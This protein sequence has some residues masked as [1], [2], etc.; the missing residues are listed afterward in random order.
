MKEFFYITILL[1]PSIVSFGQNRPK[2]DLANKLTKYFY[3]I[4]VLQS[5]DSILEFVSKDTAHYDIYYKR[6]QTDKN[7]ETMDVSFKNADNLDFYYRTEVTKEMPSTTLLLSSQIAIRQSFSTLHKA[8][9][10]SRAIKS[11]LSNYFQ[12]AVSEKKRNT[13]IGGKWKTTYLYV[14]K[15]DSIPFMSITWNNHADVTTNGCHIDIY[16]TK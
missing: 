7:I 11:E 14:N 16:I 6:R 12:K 2:Q 1:L 8:K 10:Y 9:K 4:P 13:L 5:A 3:G 15:N